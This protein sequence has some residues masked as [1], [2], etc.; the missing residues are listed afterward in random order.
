MNQK[1]VP[2]L[3]RNGVVLIGCVLSVLCIAGLLY[4]KGKSSAT[5]APEPGNHGAP[6]AFEPNL[7]QT[8]PQARYIARGHN[9]TLFLTSTGAVWSLETPAPSRSRNQSSLPASSA[10]HMDLVGANNHL[11]LSASGRQAGVSNYFIGSDPKKWRTGIPKYG[12][13]EYSQVYAGVNETVHGDRQSLTLDFEVAAGT[14]P[15]QIA[16]Q[17][18]GTSQEQLP[19]TSRLRTR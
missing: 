16:L 10:V 12:S 13:V 19:Y 6:L 9:Y 8:D 15:S 1:R 17:F 2:A 11:A 14:D 5:P 4:S 3:G 18:T 7:G